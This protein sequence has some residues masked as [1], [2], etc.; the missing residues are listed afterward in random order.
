LL[1]S[2]TLN[3]LPAPRVYGQIITPY[4]IITSME[5]LFGY[6]PLRYYLTKDFIPRSDLYRICKVILKAVA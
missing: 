6:E 4:G 3:A 2:N 5:E 1:K